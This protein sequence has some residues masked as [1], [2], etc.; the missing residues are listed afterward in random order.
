MISLVGS[1]L[2][3]NILEVFQDYN[4]RVEDDGRRNVGLTARK[5]LERLN[6]HGKLA[7]LMHNLTSTSYSK[8]VLKLKRASFIDEAGA[9]GLVRKGDR[10]TARYYKKPIVVDSKAY[11]LTN[12]WYS[13]TQKSPKQA[14]NLQ[15]LYELANGVF[16]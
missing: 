10:P 16:K 12:D 3:A 5:I 9:T 13:S 7:D 15:G 2:P 6:R 14:N 8:E 4:K 11:F 1:A